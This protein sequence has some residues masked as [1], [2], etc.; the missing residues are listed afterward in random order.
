MRIERPSRNPAAFAADNGHRVPQH[1]GHHQDH[2]NLDLSG[3]DSL[4]QVFV[5]ATAGDGSSS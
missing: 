4:D 5:N 2:I 3:L 1:P